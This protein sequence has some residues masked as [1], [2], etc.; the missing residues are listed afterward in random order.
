[1]PADCAGAPIGAS[2]LSRL[3]LSNDEVA[4]DC[5]HELRRCGDD[6]HF[7]K[8]ARKWGEPIVGRLHD[9]GAYSE[10]AFE[11]VN[12]ACQRAEAARDNL[13]SV[14]ETAVKALDTAIGEITSK[15]E[16]AL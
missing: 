7:A 9:G 12:D 16:E 15:L 6:A 5:E 11:E 10:E 14:I 3:D 8:W 4:K 2:L 13:R 1:M